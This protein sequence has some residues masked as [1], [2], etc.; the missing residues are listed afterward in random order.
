MPSKNR[1]LHLERRLGDVEGELAKLHDEIGSVSA[2]L[3]KIETADI[4]RV[5]DFQRDRWGPMASTV[6]T[7]SVL[8]WV[9]VSLAL[10]TLIATISLAI[11]MAMS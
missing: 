4:E 6:D 1:E 5:R 9:S 2:H 8:A 3:S 7:A 11:W 10:F